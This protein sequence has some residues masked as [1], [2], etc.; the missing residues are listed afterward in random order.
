MRDF[1]LRQASTRLRAA[2]VAPPLAGALTALA[3]IVNVI[4]TLTPNLRWRGH[5]LLGYEPVEW[6]RLA[7]AFALPIGAALLVVAGYLARRRARAVAVGVALLLAIGA[8]DLVK[9][10]DYE[11]ALLS[12]ALAVLLVWGRPAFR[13]RHAVD[14][15]R[16]AALRSCALA[17]LAYGVAVAAVWATQRAA[18]PPLGIARILGVALRLLLLLDSGL[19]FHRPFGWVPVGVGLLGV[20]TLLTAAYTVFRPLAAPRTLPPRATWALACSL[21]RRHGHDTLSFFKLRQDKQYI[22]SADRRA[23]A[24]YRVEGAILLLSGDPIGPP[25]ALPALI[26]DICA[27]AEIRG[28]K[29][30]GV[31]AGEPMLPLYRAAGLRSFYLGDEAVVELERFSLVGRK[32]RKLRQSVSRL[33]KAGYSSELRPVGELADGELAALEEISAHWRDGAPERGFSMAMDTLGGGHQEDSLVVVARDAGGAVRGF[34]HFVPCYGRAA[35]SLSFM[36]RDRDTP[37]GLTEYMVAEAI[38]MLRERGVAEISLNFATFARI[39]HSPANLRDRALA[40][41]V[42]LANPYF[43]IES[44]Y[45]FN[46]KFAPRWESRYLVYEGTLGLPRVGLAALLAEGQL[47]R[48]RGGSPVRSRLPV[49]GRRRVAV[50]R[51]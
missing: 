47:P 17:A 26:R 29:V 22:F 7:H 45:R 24:A 39:L 34:L 4:S 33:E 27:F 19:H 13:V 30:G 11:E 32:V 10:L 25:D 36:R 51:G 3:G 35:M 48:L 43:Q 16:G 42:A 21:V 2:R 5:V 31:G 1:R 40:R 41:L 12:W 8:L 15:L 49:R 50:H 38:A 44:L 23:F 37:N 28:L 18:A 46:A 9:G 14:G 20:G 6:M